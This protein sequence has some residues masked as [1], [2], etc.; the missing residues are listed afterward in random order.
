[1]A[2]Q[3]LLQVHNTSDDPG[4]DGNNLSLPLQDPSLCTMKCDVHI[5]LTKFSL[6]V[7]FDVRREKKFLRL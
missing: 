7:R 3:F 1:M 5:L 2:S 4:Y 6:I